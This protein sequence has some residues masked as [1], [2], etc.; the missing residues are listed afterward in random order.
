MISQCLNL[1]I[2]LSDE[3]L[4]DYFI[5]VLKET[6]FIRYARTKREKKILKI[7]YKTYRFSVKNIVVDNYRSQLI[8]STVF[9]F[10]F[11]AFQTFIIKL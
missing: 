1:L 4:S 10:V 7:G 8:V 11:C 6:P 9:I 5:Q 2:K 3:W